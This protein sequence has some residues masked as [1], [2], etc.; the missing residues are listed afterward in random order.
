MD[1][2]RPHIFL[3]RTFRRILLDPIISLLISQLFHSCHNQNQLAQILPIIKYTLGG[4]ILG[5]EEPEMN[6]LIV[7][8]E[9]LMLE[10][11]RIGFE[12]SGYR[13]LGA[14]GA[15]QALD[16][17]NRGGQ[18]IDLIVTDY[19]M[20]EM[21]GI[22]LLKAVRKSHPTLPVII[23]SANSD[24]NLLIEA[25][26]NRC[27][28]FIEKPFSLDQ[29]VAEIERLKNNILPIAKFNKQQKLFPSLL[30]Q[31]NDPLF[32]IGVSAELILE[33]RSAGETLQRH[34]KNIIEAVTQ[35]NHIF[36]EI[37]FDVQACKIDIDE[38]AHNQRSNEVEERDRNKYIVAMKQ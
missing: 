28:G 24:K 7:E 8:D 32:A 29:L 37:L 5:D 13:V 3:K 14:L 31:V 4:I 34:A 26:K 23:M 6:I 27:D 18:R 20:P 21:N 16:H 2:P 33:D 38:D 19:W 25:M 11:I 17:L 15:R 1:Q 30:H 10:S 36:E 22:D 12:N 35:V 9:S